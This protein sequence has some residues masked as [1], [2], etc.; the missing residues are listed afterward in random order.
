GE[1]V[2]DALGDIHGGQGDDE[3][4][5]LGLGDDDAVEQAEEQ[6]GED[7]H[8]DA[9]DLGHTAPDHGAGAQHAGHGDDGAHRQVDA[10]QDDDHGHA[11][12]QQQ[13]GGILAQHVKEVALGEEVGIG[14]EVDKHDH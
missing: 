2:G 7:A 6:A 3:R 13:V 12:G 14:P 5:D 8:Q 1:H 10:A 9:H 11:A 4:R